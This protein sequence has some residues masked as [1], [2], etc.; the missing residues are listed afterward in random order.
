MASVEHNGNFT[1]GDVVGYESG[2]EFYGMKVLESMYVGSGVNRTVYIGQS[3][4][5]GSDGEFK[6]YGDGTEMYAYTMDRLKEDYAYKYVKEEKLKD[7]DVLRTSDGK[8][9]FVVRGFASYDST[10][11]RLY[12]VSG[13]SGLH[14]TRKNYEAEYGKLSLVKTSDYSG[15]RFS[16]PVE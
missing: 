3:G 2:T 11:P 13:G 14:D 15:V 5:I 12:R 9:V 10:V 8:H 16:A 1:Y 4:R 7:G 6:P